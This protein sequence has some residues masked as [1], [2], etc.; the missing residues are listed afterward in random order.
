MTIK[1]ELGVKNLQLVAIV[2]AISA[3]LYWRL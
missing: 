1:Y 2:K 3:H